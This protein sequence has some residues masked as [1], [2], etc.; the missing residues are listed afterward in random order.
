MTRKA[1]ELTE[2][3]AQ[4]L[5]RPHSKPA[6]HPKPKVLDTE[7]LSDPF[8]EIGKADNEA[9]QS[10]KELFNEGSGLK[11]KTDI[12]DAEVFGLSRVKFISHVFN[13]P[14]LDIWADE[15]LKLRI[16][17]KRK[18]RLEFLDAIKRPQEMLPRMGG[19]FGGKQF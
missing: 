5:A 19:M 15:F 7:P 12:D 4:Q 14:T 1:R 6:C 11:L 18:G 9:L 17:R 13:L 2:H 16:S 10:A 8:S 3:E